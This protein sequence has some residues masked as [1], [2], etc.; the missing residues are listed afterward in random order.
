MS[1]QQ[2][3]V[4]VM[5]RVICPVTYAV[6]AGGTFAMDKSLMFHRHP[7]SPPH[8]H[9]YYLPLMSC[10]GFRTGEPFLFSLK[11]KI[12]IKCETAL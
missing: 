9:H 12:T 8:T 1:P 11:N 4:Y 5:M 2:E 7:V 6:H 3:R 10:R